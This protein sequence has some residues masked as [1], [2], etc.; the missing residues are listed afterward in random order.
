MATCVSFLRVPDISRTIQWHEDIGFKCLGI[1]QEPGCVLD[2]ALLDWEGGQFMLY[3]GER[4]N[5]REQK[6]AGLYFA[7]AS[8]DDIIEVLKEKAEIIEINPETEYGRK[9]IVFKDIN[10]F[11]VT[12]GCEPDNKYK[13][14][15]CYHKRHIQ[16]IIFIFAFALTGN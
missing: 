4:K 3:P 11:Q 12:F 8:I 2:K 14:I 10:G 13:W 15:Y 6:D 1:H 16:K 7:I 5:H 9:E